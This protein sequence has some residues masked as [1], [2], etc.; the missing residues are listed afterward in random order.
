MRATVYAR[1]LSNVAALAYDPEGHLWASTAA[2]STGGQDGVYMIE[3]AGSPPLKV[4]SGLSTPLGLLW[5]TGTLFVSSSGRVDAYSGFD[6]SAFT[7]RDQVIAFPAGTGELNNIVASPDGRIELG[8]SAPCDHCRPASKWSAAIVSFRPDGTDLRLSAGGIRAPFGLAYSPGGELIVSMNQRDDLGS[9]TPGDW[10]AVV[11]RGQAWGFPDC[12]GQ[13]GNACVNTP[14]PIAVLDPHAAAGGLTVV[15]SE[16]LVAEWA[17][18]GVL[19]VALETHRVSPWLTGLKNPLPIMTAPDGSVVVGDW[20]T[21]VIY[22]IN[23][24]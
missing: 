10:L 2:Y 23:K 13:A 4:I 11:K 12:Y 1:G 6:G 14:K 19:R 3:N 5:S 9:A 15:G 8:I 22:R 21:G 24:R 20:K 17:K 16:A 7:H 18:G